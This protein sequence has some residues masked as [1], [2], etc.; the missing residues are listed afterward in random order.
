MTSEI[1][2]NR[3]DQL[4]RRVGGII[5]PGSK[6]A[7]V[8]TELF[9]VIDVERVPGELLWLAGTRVAF[10]GGVAQSAVAE[11]QAWQIFN[12]ADSGHIITVTRASLASNFAEVFSM[13]MTTT[14]FISQPGTETFR[15][16]RG[17]SSSPVGTIGEQS[18]AGGVS[19]NFSAAVGIAEPYIWEDPNGIA[20]LLPGSGLN[21][22]G[23]ITNSTLSAG[24]FWRER[25]AEESELNV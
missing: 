9:P 11:R 16:S 19:Q 20:V 13:D 6:V 21:I 8:I 1:Q 3:Y 7:E 18:A 17:G 12:P 25:V 24:F 4:I 22:G 23:D 5:G 10:G 2:Q 15:D 14:Q